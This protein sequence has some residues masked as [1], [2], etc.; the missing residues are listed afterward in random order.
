[1]LAGLES[2][3]VALLLPLAV[4]GGAAAWRS[5]RASGLLLCMFFIV[6]AAGLGATVLS[7]GTLFRLRLSAL[8]PFL[9]LAGVGWARWREDRA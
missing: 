5:G 1:M 4:A 8:V 7:V 3:V 6:I 2:V 9:V